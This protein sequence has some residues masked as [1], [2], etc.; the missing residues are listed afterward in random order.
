MSDLIA[1][2]DDYTISLSDGGMSDSEVFE[3]LRD[4][5]AE[6]KRLIVWPSEL[7]DKIGQLRAEIER[8]TEQLK[9]QKEYYENVI[10]DGVKQIK[11]Q[12]MKRLETQGMADCMDMVMQELQGAGV[13][14]KDI[15]PM[16]LPEAI[17]AKLSAAGEPASYFFSGKEGSF[18]ASDLKQGEAILKLM[19]VDSDDW[20]ATELPAPP[21]VAALI[22]ERQALLDALKVIVSAHRAIAMCEEPK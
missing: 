10:E 8:L 17:M 21:S 13:I 6:I 20:T 15:P 9:T 11:E 22:A 4:C 1:R 16:M 14:S 2:I 7:F 5:K 18:Y 3:L 19:N 12:K